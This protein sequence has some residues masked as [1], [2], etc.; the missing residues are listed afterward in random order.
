MSELINA[1][2]TFSV[3]QNTFGVH[4]GKVV[5]ILE[6][7][8]PKSVPESLS[9]V[10]GVMDHR[11]MIV[12]VIDTGKKFNVGAVEVT[13]QTCIVIL[14]IDKPDRSGTF[15]IGAMVDEVS[16]VFESETENLKA[17]ENDFKPAYISATYKKNDG[18]IM[19]LNTDEVFNE[20][21]IIELDKLKQRLESE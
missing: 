2:L 4:V 19:I 17:I 21:D 7:E 18:L 13:P 20:K 12:P 3:Q 10:I 11:E 15:V 8:K 16:D 9:Y 6:Y 5:E 1:Y 14:E